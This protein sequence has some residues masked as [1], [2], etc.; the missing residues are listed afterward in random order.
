MCVCVQ[1][2]GTIVDKSGRT[3]SGQTGEAFIISVS[4]TQPLWWES[5]WPLHSL[6]LTSSIF[7]ESCFFT[8]PQRCL[9]SD[10][11]SLCSSIGL[12]CALGASEMRPFIEAIGKSTGAFVICY[13][14]AGVFTTEHDCWIY[15]TL[16]WNGILMSNKLDKC[17]SS[18]LYNMYFTVFWSVCWFSGLPNTFG[19]YDETPNV[20]ASHLK[21]TQRYTNPVNVSDGVSHYTRDI[22]AGVCG[23]RF[24]E[25]CWW[26]LRNDTRS[27]PVRENDSSWVCVSV[28]I[29]ELNSV[30]VFQGD[31]WKCASRQTQSS[32]YRRVQWLYAAVRCVCLHLY[33]AL[34]HLEVTLAY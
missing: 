22:P 32:S 3:L 30:C 14:N 18:T 4:H 31:C 16:W 21:V 19:G 2:S 33:T 28:E 12:N 7:N 25:Y 26:L 8:D 24:G 20:T 15:A 6:L 29:A 23:G 13:P 34:P 11:V 10:I 1:I 27:H 17:D 9:L 5:V